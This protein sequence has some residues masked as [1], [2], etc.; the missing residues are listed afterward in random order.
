M[1]HPKVNQPYT[2]NP[3]PALLGS[4]HVLPELHTARTTRALR[5]PFEWQQHVSVGGWL[6]G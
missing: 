2:L 5:V 3:N 1:V 4:Y 6:V